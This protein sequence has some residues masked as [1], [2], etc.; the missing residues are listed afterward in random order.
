MPAFTVGRISAWMIKSKYFIEISMLI[1]RSLWPEVVWPN[2]TKYQHLGKKNSLGHLLDIEYLKLGDILIYLFIHFGWFF[3]NH[4]VTVILKWR[5]P[6]PFLEKFC[7]F[8][9][10]FDKISVEFLILLLIRIRRR[11]KDSRWRIKRWG[12]FEPIPFN[13]VSDACHSQA[14]CWCVSDHRKIKL[15]P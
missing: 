6:L 12:G 3:S 8:R 13:W 7:L 2:W 11:P 15:R 9:F 5:V 4:L 14:L 1:E 10:L